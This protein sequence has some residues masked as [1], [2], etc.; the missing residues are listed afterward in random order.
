MRFRSN[1]WLQSIMF[2]F[3]VM[4]IVLLMLTSVKKSFE[5]W[6]HRSA[7][8]PASV[9]QFFTEATTHFRDFSAHF[10]SFRPTLRVSPPPFDETRQTTGRRLPFACLVVDIDLEHLGSSRELPKWC[11]QDCLLF[12]NG[13]KVQRESS[14]AKLKLVVYRLELTLWFTRVFLGSLPC[15]HTRTPKNAQTHR[16]QD[17]ECSFYSDPS[18]HKIENDTYRNNQQKEYISVSITKIPWLSSSYCIIP[19][20]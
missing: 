19:S 8:W 7:V 9:T 6:M 13:N 5:K 1:W 16:R 15:E 12:I 18:T 11:M 17:D 4:I 2:L 3:M 10:E 20:R 14:F